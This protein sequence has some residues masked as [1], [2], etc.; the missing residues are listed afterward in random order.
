MTITF[1]KIQWYVAFPQQV[2]SFPSRGKLHITGKLQ[3]ANTKTV[4]QAVSEF[5]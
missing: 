3:Q 5:L 2:P 1:G 4:I